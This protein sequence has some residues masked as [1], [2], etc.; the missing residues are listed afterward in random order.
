MKVDWMK[1]LTMGADKTGPNWV[2]DTK[3]K[4]IQTLSFLEYMKHHTGGVPC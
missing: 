1:L 4:F 3:E 2:G